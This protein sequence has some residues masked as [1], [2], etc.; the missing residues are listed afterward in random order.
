MKASPI[1]GPARFTQP[2]CFLDAEHAYKANKAKQHGITIIKPFNWKR[3][4]RKRLKWCKARYILPE[5]IIWNIRFS[6]VFY[7]RPVSQPSKRASLPHVISRRNCL[8]YRARPAT[9]PARL[10]VIRALR[11]IYTS[12]FCFDFWLLTWLYVTVINSLP[13][14]GDIY[15]D[16]S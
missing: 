12:D 15:R 16:L 13:C 3:S 7:G 9:G 4:V 14:S 8:G 6:R 10:H 2:G 11:P 5:G 1:T